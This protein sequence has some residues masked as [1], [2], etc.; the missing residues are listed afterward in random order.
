MCRMD[1][2]LILDPAQCTSISD[3]ED[4]TPAVMQQTRHRVCIHAGSAVTLLLLLLLLMLLLL[5]LLLLL[6]AH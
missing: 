5:L 3:E 2:T 6:Q 1:V 4:N